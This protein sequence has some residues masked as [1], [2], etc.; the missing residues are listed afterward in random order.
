MRIPALMGRYV[1]V[2]PDTE[3]GHYGVMDLE[4]YEGEQAFIKCPLCGGQLYEARCD[5]FRVVKIWDGLEGLA[6]VVPATH[7]GFEC[8]DCDVGFTLPKEDAA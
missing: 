8:E 6:Q 3:V 2:T 5:L 4:G 1:E 7:R